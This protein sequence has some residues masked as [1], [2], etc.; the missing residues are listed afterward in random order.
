MQYI[1]HGFY[2]IS[3]REAS[4]LAKEAPHGRLPRHGYFINVLLSDGRKAELHRT[5]YGVGLHTDA[6]KRG[7]VWAVMPY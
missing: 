1:S 5:L 3:D 2:R 7:W 6:P 4:R